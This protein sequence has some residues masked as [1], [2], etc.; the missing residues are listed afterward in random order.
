MEDAATVT[1]VLLFTILDG[2]TGA[3]PGGEDAELKL[4]IFQSVMEC[5]LAALEKIRSPYHRILDI[6][7]NV[8]G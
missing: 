8:G 3:G 7:S 4:S 1:G 5:C 2:G 6:I